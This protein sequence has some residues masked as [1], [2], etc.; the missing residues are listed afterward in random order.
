MTANP[1]TTLNGSLSGTTLADLCQ[2]MGSRTGVLELTHQNEHARIYFNQ[3]VLVHAELG[4]LFGK[5]AFLDAVQWRDGSFQF[6]NGALPSY[7]SI[8][9]KITALIM[10][11]AVY[12]D[13][14]EQL[15]K[16]AV[17]DSTYLQ[18]TAV[19]EDRV[20]E[21]FKDAAS[22]EIWN[23]LAEPHNIRGVVSELLPLG[24]TKHDVVSG[25]WSLL[26]TGAIRMATPGSAPAQATEPTP[27]A[28]PSLR[29][30]PQMQAASPAPQSAPIWLIP[31]LIAGALAL[32]GV[33]WWLSQKSPETPASLAQAEPTASL[34]NANPP[35]ADATP[36]RTPVAKGLDSL[37]TAAL[38][39]RQGEDVVVLGT[40]VRTNVD[41]RSGI[42]FLDFR[43]RPKEGFVLIIY[44]DDLS[45]WQDST[46][47]VDQY[48]GKK[49]RVRGKVTIYNGLP[50][51]VVKEP[52]QIEI[53]ED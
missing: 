51:V 18:S 6:I 38:V 17:Y 7:V 39:E 31:S 44:P 32:G 46:A 14:W 15:N 47:P 23:R 48:L 22:V 50:Q 5:D 28:A 30:R 42:T 40:I 12:H 34:A 26:E 1:T 43:S 27:A 13:I 25:F 24:Y 52:T 37:D 16:A 4:N 41:S 10:E 19:E 33:F 53:V 8:Q 45:A 11:A 21:V 35:P 9:D 49:V 2:I 36:V 29:Q 3:G 20:A